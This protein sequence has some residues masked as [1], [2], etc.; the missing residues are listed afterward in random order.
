MEW[1]L[2]KLIIDNV[3]NTDFRFSAKKFLQKDSFMA[4]LDIGDCIGLLVFCLSLRYKATQKPV[5]LKVYRW[6]LCGLWDTRQRFYRPRSR[7]LIY[8][9]QLV[10]FC[11]IG[12]N[13][14]PIQALPSHC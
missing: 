10:I 4:L 13:Y 11:E 7:I 14:S 8:R 1:I 5:F 12:R 9:I 2:Y 3:H 6:K